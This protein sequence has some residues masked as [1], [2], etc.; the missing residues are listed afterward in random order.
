[1]KSLKA[2][3]Y[4]N[5]ILIMGILS[6]FKGIFGGNDFEQHLEIGKII[7]P[8]NDNEISSCFNLFKDNKKKFKKDFKMLI[9]DYEFDSDNGSLTELLFSYG[10][11]KNK[12]IYIDWR[13]E[14]NEGEIEEYIL[15][16]IENKINFKNTTELRKKSVDIEQRDG[17]YIKQLLLN[18]NKDLNV[19]G[20]EVLYFNI[21]W[22][23]YGFIIAEKSEV[24]KILKISNKILKPTFE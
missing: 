18:I 5:L 16:I 7:Y 14:E 11:W 21:D 3:I 22:D 9:D 19:A 6:S 10:D 15:E 12:T 1:M 13:G 23:G 24:Q 8:K 20:Y 17:K 2:L 4:V